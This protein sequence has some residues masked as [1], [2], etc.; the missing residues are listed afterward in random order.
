M[1]TMIISTASTQHTTFINLYNYG[2]KEENVL[3]LFGGSGSTLIACEEVRDV[4]K[5]EETSNGTAWAVWVL[6]GAGVVIVLII[7]TKFFL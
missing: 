4:E 3:D 1:N 6:V 5:K 2:R 7:A